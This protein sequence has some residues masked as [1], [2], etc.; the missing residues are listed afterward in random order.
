MR[1]GVTLSA[2]L[3]EEVTDPSFTG[4]C[5]ISFGRAS[6]SLVLEHGKCMLA[7]YPPLKGGDAWN[8]IKA[9]G[10][11]QVD[12]E[13]SDI[14]DTQV[15]LALEFNKLA[16]VDSSRPS[17]IIFTKTESVTPSEV[18]ENPLKRSGSAKSASAP[19]PQQK[20]EQREDSRIPE[21]DGFVLVNRDLDRLDAMDLESMTEKIRNSCKS[22]VRRLH[23]G[24]LL[25]EPTN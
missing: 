6:C 25:E 10:D 22:T 15:Q 5:I 8:A 9:I 19:L 16:R 20:R 3:D 12:A 21:G 4:Y 18:I 11:T 2:F 13:L 1:K 14:T 7:E 24:H 17:A 23:L